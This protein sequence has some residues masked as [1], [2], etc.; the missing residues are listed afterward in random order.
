MVRHMHQAHRVYESLLTGVQEGRY[1][2]GQR[3]REEEIARAFNVSRTP[4]REA[5]SRL[6]E[7]GLLEMT[8]QGLVVATLTRPQVIE[9]YAMRAILEG[10][11]ARF[12][13]Q[14]ASPSDISALKYLAKRFGQ[15]LDE[16]FQL[17]HVNR[18]FHAAIYDAAHNRYLMRTLQ[19]VHDVLALFP[20][21]T[22]TIPGRPEQTVD[23]HV[24]IVSAVERRDADKAEQAARHHIERAQEAWLDLLF[25]Y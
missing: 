4:V 15:L 3:V 17:A 7:R 25:G 2:Q 24:A 5:L 22:F 1:Q 13:A 18:E 10:S 14:H 19:E 23:E 21:T 16:P 11:A 20:G 9:L 8:S 6:Q 12:A